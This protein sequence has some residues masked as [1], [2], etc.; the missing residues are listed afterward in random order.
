MPNKTHNNMI[1]TG[2]NEVAI[3]DNL[4]APIGKVVAKSSQ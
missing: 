2:D 1:A 4:N 3:K